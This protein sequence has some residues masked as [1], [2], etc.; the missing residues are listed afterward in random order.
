MCFFL[1]FISNPSGNSIDI[2]S[3]SKYL[4]IPPL[5][6]SDLKYHHLSSGLLQ[7]PFTHFHI[8]SPC[9]ASASPPSILNS[10]SDH[11]EFNS[12]CNFSTQSPEMTFHFIKS[13]SQSL[14]GLMLSDSLCFSSGLFPYDPHPSL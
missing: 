10:K 8:C 5:L 3:K 14:C 12:D 11:F 6:P 13:K 7:Q 4:L 9:V 2:T 1:H